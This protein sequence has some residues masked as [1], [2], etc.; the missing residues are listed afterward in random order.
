VGDANEI[1]AELS[2]GFHHVQRGTTA[3]KTKE[4]P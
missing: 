4:M 2:S 1:D 3:G